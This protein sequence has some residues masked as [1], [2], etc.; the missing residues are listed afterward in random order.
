MKNIYSIAAAFLL[1]TSMNGQIHYSENFE[2]LNINTW[3]NS[4]LDGDGQKFFLANANAIYPT[5][6]LGSKTLVS[7]SYNNK[8]LTPNN[9]ITSTPI[10]LPSGMSNL[11]LKFQVGSYNGEYGSEHYAVYISPTDNP[12][13]VIATTPVKEETLPFAGGMKEVSVDVSSYAGQTV[14]LSVRH[15]NV[16]DMYYLLFD[17][18]SI[19]TL[20]NNNAQLVSGSINKYIAANSQNDLTY[21][22]KNRGAN[23]ITSVELNWNDGAD[24]IATVPTNIAVGETVTVVHPTKVSYSTVESKNLNL[25]INKVNGAAD[26]DPTDNNGT[27]VTSVASQFT[28]KIVVLEEGT[29]TWCGYCPRGM[30]GLNKVNTDYPN[31]QISIAIHAG[32]A[33]EPMRLLEYE[34]GAAFSGYPGMNVDRVLK[35]VDPGPNDINSYVTSRK[36]I[37]TPVKLSG[38]YAISGNQLTAN[39]NSQ[40]F[41]NNPNTNFKLAVVVLEDG[42]KGTT[43]N[44]GHVNYYSGGQMGPMGG[45]ENLPSTVP[46]SQMVYDHVA[47]ALLGGYSGQPGS[48]PTA[49]T[50]G[51]TSSYTFSYTIP[52]TYK[53][54]NLHAVVLLIDSDGTILN[55]S[56]LSKTLAVNDASNLG[57]KMS[58][59]P[60][61]AK[62]EFN[63]KLVDDGMYD[64][65]IYDMT[66]REVKNLGEIK[67]SSKKITIPINLTAGKYLVNITKDGVSYTKE[68][69]VK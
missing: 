55:A 43:S 48:V 37:P 36:D 34:V 21:S 39:V 15:F 49:I 32:N 33:S 23:P 19:E 69:L 17:N 2:S 66:G 67:S 4:D 22:I 31:D 9:L 63:I 51:A 59:Y 64:V 27:A 28:P 6:N 56:K 58:I 13:E 42:V 26:S 12:N 65:K 54:D 44:Y 11:I 68:L 52:A 47:R 45:F 1:A 35:G 50:D 24:H 10:T 29:G 5:S 7:Y 53:A 60:N 62:S 16:S 38:D 57:A 46:A 18:I 20:Q 61:P 25:T 8:V 30:V 40:F 14:Y 41:I 3:K